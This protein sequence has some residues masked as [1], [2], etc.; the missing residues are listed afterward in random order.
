MGRPSTYVTTV[1]DEIVRRVSEGEPL[2]A[3][4]RDES[5]PAVRTVSDWRKAHPDFDE[6]FLAARDDGFDALAAQCIDIADDET[7]DWVLS[8]KGPLVNETA[9]G[10]SRLRVDT[11]LKLLSKWDPRRYGDSMTL[12]GDKENPLA[13]HSDEQINARIAELLAKQQGQGDA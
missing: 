10:R 9:I 11:R 4:C 7:E 5:M 2:A 13:S 3:I 12:K 1:A 6:R 8:K